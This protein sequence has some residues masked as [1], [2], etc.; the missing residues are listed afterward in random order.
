MQG[1]KVPQSAQAGVNV[2]LGCWFWRNLQPE[3]KPVRS[4]KMAQ[5][6]QKTDSREFEVAN[7]GPAPGVVA[8]RSGGRCDGHRDSA[9]GLGTGRIVGHR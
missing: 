7:S 8:R 4:E 9:L 1:T 2:C 3:F 6:E 5:Y